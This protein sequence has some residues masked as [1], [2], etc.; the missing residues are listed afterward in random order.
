[1]CHFSFAM[2]H[3]SRSFWYCVRNNCLFCRLLKEQEQVPD[4]WF[5]V[6]FVPRYT[7]AIKAATDFVDC[8]FEDIFLV[9]NA[10]TGI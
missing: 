7:R 1:M 6:T 4:Q 10:T 9:D 5:R 3:C 8:D 2:C